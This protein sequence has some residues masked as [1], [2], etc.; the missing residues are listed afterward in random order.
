MTPLLSILALAAGDRLARRWRLRTWGRIAAV[1][2]RAFGPGC[3]YQRIAVDVRYAG[4]H[5]LPGV[6]CAKV[7][8]IR[9]SR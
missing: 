9:D 2:A 5:P 8:L 6:L 7:D 3:S 4:C 1:G